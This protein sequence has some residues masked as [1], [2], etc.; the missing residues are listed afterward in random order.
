MLLYLW[1]DNQ[2]DEFEENMIRYLDFSLMIDDSYSSWLMVVLSGKINAARPPRARQCFW[3]RGFLCFTLMTWL[4]TLSRKVVSWDT[5][6]VVT[7]LAASFPRLNL[8]CV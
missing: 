4:Q 7:G 2:V 3:G 6:M 8:N 1:V 5:T